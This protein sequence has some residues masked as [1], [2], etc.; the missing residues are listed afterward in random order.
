[1]E[2]PAADPSGN[3]VMTLGDHLDE[4]RRRVL[5]A[6]VVP[7]PVAIAAF[8]FA[9]PIRDALCE[10]A[11][12]ALRAHDL[13]AQLQV[14]NPI[15]TLGSEL[16][17]SLVA[18]LVLAAP[19]I[20]LQIWKFVEPGLYAH[21]R[22]FVR[23][24]VPMSAILTIVGLAL[25][26]FVLLP[27]MLEVLVSIGGE[28]PT[29]LQAGGPGGGTQA[30]V[31]PTLAE[32]PAR[33]QPGQMWLTPDH[34]LAVAVPVDAEHVEV[35]T[36]VLAHDA[37]LMQ[38]FRLSEYLDFTLDFALGITIAFQTPLVVL[39]LGWLGVLTPSSLARQRRY[40]IFAAAVIGA[41]VTPSGDPFSM[42]LLAVPVYLLY[43]LGILLLRIAP[44]SAVARG[45]VLDRLLRVVRGRET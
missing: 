12:R 11:L 42:A 20:A 33:P 22:R 3:A 24:L 32:A 36:V 39:L 15:E 2:R 44:P 1:M 28:P 9:A 21:E 40:A 13:P 37:R 30:T 29:L 6:L 14:L 27:L 23:L 10:P 5:M 26:Y 45:E 16:K 35:R 4:L 43:E 31:V 17:L 38:Q 41:V 18:A 19:W 34:R 7:V 25:L 8:T